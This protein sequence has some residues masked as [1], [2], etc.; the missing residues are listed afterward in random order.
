VLVALR[1][2]YV[3]RLGITELEALARLAKDAILAQF[4]GDVDRVYAR[5]SGFRLWPL[6][7][8]ADGHMGILPSALGPEPIAR[9]QSGGLKAGEV[10]ARAMQKAVAG[11]A[12]AVR[13]SV[14]AG[15]GQAIAEFGAS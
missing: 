4:W 2:D 12:E 3:P 14:A 5:R 13:A 15:F 1:P 7:A 8:P 9:L 11:H 10:M 6:T